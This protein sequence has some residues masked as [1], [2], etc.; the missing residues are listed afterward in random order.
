MSSGGGPGPY[1]FAL[2]PSLGREPVREMVERF[3]AHFQGSGIERIEPLSSY[4]E[5]ETALL[6]GYCHAAWSP[7]IVCARIESAGGMVALRSVRYGS[8]TYRA[9]LLCRASDRISLKELGLPGARQLRAVWVD[10]WSMGG[11]ILPR[12]YLRSR[13][14]ELGEILSEQH[15]LESYGA[16]FNAVLDG[17]ADLTASYATRRGL[18]YVDL[19]GDR[20]VELRALAYTD[21]SPNDGIALSP[22]LPRPEAEALRATLAEYLSEERAPEL[23]SSGFD[24]NAFDQPPPGTYSALLSLL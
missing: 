6:Q 10:E 11:C 22:T 24:V 7:P 8:T 1:V 23:L 12:Y 17:H 20:A 16:C 21:E 4:A 9:V 3:S 19:C 18:G 5:L 15:L 2:P 14:L 13:G